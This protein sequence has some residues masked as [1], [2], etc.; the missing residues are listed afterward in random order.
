MIPFKKE[1]INKK[2]TPTWVY[3]NDNSR[4]KRFRDLFIKQFGGEFIKETRHTFIWREL[5]KEE[6]PRRKFVFE[7]ANGIVFVVENMYEFCKK[8]DLKRPAL[9]EVISGK[10]KSHKGYKFIAEI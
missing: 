1:D 3:C 10:R 4:S 6:K 9:Y 2:Y 7:D 8:N 5:Q